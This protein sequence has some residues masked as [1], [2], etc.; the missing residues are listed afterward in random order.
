MG[1]IISIALIGVGIYCSVFLR[2]KAI[3]DVTE[4]KFMKTKTID[5]LT[6]IFSQ[7][8]DSGLGDTYR[9]FVELKGIVNDENK[10]ETP[11]SKKEVAYCESITYE[12]L[13]ETK[14]HIDSNGRRTTSTQKR[15]EE[16]S[17]EKSSQYIS[18]KDNSSNNSVILEI[19]GYG[20]KFD[21]PETYDRF[22]S[23]SDIRRN[24][25]NGVNITINNYSHNN[26]KLLGYRF[27]EK[28][29]NFS[30]SLYVI[31]EA[32]RRDGKIYIGK[33]QDSKKPF[34]VTTKSEED[35][36]NTSNTRAITLLIGGI[37][38][39]IGGII[40]LINNI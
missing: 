32:F 27:K 30:Q 10:T 25:I 37:L 2:K 40:Y 38:L 18:M 28:T 39:I 11:F 20:C 24:P 16:L 31:G 22:Q 4:I 35:L 15:E 9:E 17:R 19:N 7:M 14:E 8:D 34:I 3:D 21:I 1:I 33:P 23:E 6:E 29:I 12:V 36:I 13:Q 5:E 26:S